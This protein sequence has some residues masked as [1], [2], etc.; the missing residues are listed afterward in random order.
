[1]SS[2]WF[3]QSSNPHPLLMFYNSSTSQQ[4]GLWPTSDISWP[5]GYGLKWYRM[6]YAAAHSFGSKSIAGASGVLEFYLFG[7]TTSYGGTSLPN[8]PFIVKATDSYSGCDPALPKMTYLSKIDATTI[9]CSTSI[10]NVNQS[11]TT[12]TLVQLTQLTDFAYMVVDIYSAT[13]YS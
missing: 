12:S 6:D 13:I 7:S 5:T 2:V 8:A 11:Y 10:S 3:T 4:E 1:M 9:P